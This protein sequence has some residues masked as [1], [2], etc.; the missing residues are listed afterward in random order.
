MMSAL[1]APDTNAALE[2]G[3]NALF[4]LLAEHIEDRVQPLL[5]TVLAPSP[6]G[7]QLQRLYSSDPRNFPLSAA[8]T[9][10]D[11]RWFRHL[12]V[13][14]KPIVANDPE[15]ILS[16]LPDWRSL[17]D[18]GYGSLVN[19]PLVTAG[20][21]IGL[22]NVMAAPGHFVSE[23]VDALKAECPPRRTCHHGSAVGH[24]K[25]YI[26]RSD[27]IRPN[28]IQRTQV[29]PRPKPLIILNRRIRCA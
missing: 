21:A 23:R 18:M 14:M 20:N 6:G 4:E 25:D 12:F 19:M 28:S 9:V 26:W 13:D 8:D 15:T 1:T 22:I 5:F 17:I 3:A 29:L 7:H 11:N 27:S 24:P 16:W 10:E 2:Q